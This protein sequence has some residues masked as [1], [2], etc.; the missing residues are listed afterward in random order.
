MAT[1]FFISAGS[2]GGSPSGDPNAVS[3]FSPSGAALIDDPKLTAAPVDQFG[4]PQILDRRQGALLEGA[5]LRQG[6]WVADGDP[7]NQT[8]EGVVVYGP[9]NGLLDASNGMIGRVKYD[10]FQLRR[11]VGGVDIGSAFRVDPTHLFLTN[12]FGTVTCEIIRANGHA[13]FSQ[14]QVNGASGPSWRAGLGPPEGFLVGSPGDLYSDPT[15]APGAV[16]FVKETGVNT[17]TGWVAK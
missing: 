2:G 9:A 5:V 7:V 1:A 8:G 16:F 12:D 17:P 4:R 3:Y 15:G 13:F 11:I 6:G 14:V 10:R